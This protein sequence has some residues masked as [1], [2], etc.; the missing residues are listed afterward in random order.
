MV[1]L[2]IRIDDE[3]KAE[4]DS[5][6]SELGLDTPTAVRM[7]IKAAIDKKG[8]PFSIKKSKNRKPNAETLE[9]MEDVRMNRNLYGPFSTV[10]DAMKFMLED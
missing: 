3:L 10:D 6:F 4:A 7:F 5:L 2:Q 9:A 1:T 8:I